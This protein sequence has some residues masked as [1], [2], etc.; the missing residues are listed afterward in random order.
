ML[1]MSNY[2]FSS[3][4]PCCDAGCNFHLKRCPVR[5]SPE[6][7]FSMCY[8]YLFLHTGVI[9]NSNSGCSL[10]HLTGTRRV[11]HELLIIYSVQNAVF[12]HVAANKEILNQGF[13][14]DKLKSSLRKCY[15]HH[16]DLVNRNEY[17][18]H[19]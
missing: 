11:S 1:F 7:M 6:V 9:H 3:F 12:S 10:C 14:V 5:F 18:S 4:V 16:H 17:L 19:K 2:I 15:G 13:P 8:F